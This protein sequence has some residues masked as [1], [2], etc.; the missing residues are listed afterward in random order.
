MSY[1]NGDREAICLRC[2]QR[3]NSESVIRIVGEYA[4]HEATLAL[5]QRL[6][7]N[8]WGNKFAKFAVTK[9]PRRSF[10][11]RLVGR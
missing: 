1:A 9:T 8:G 5:E 6:A 2:G 4:Q 3:D 10:R 7:G 11:W